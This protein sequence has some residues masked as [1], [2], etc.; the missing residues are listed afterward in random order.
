M[1]N[2]EV[3]LNLEMKR[4]LLHYSCHRVRFRRNKE[5]LS[6]AIAEKMIEKLVHNYTINIYLTMH[7]KS[8]LVVTTRSN[9]K[10][11]LLLTA[12]SI[13]TYFWAATTNLH[14]ERAIIFMVS[15]ISSK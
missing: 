6:L 3:Q 12:W 14:F 13:T 1:E 5:L 8:R 15:K 10:S 11:L 9:A 7:I 2:G 4:C